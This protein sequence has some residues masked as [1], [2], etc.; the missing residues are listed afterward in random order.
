M[1]TNALY[2]ASATKARRLLIA[3]MLAVKIAII[4]SLPAATSHAVTKLTGR[5]YSPTQYAEIHFTID[6]HKLQRS[7]KHINETLRQA[8]GNIKSKL[9]QARVPSSGLTSDSQLPTYLYSQ[10]ATRAQTLIS[11]REKI[12]KIHPLL[13][14]SVVDEH[15]ISR[16]KRDT[17]QLVSHT[18]TK[19]GLGGLIGKAGQFLTKTVSY[20][21]MLKTAAFGGVTSVLSNILNIGLSS[22]NTHQLGQLEEAQEDIVAEIDALD[23]EIEDLSES[24]QNLTF[25]RNIRAQLDFSLAIIDRALIHLDQNILRCLLYTSPSPRDS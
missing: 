8:K 1:R 17:E 18:R 14:A 9:N 22:Y 19:R 3:T 13:I 16:S 7:V 12:N 24:I 4:I 15:H 11:A 20:G 25:H 23:M 6:T 2:A 21:G 10:I 5:L